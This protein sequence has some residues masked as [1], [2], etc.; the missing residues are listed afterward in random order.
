MADEHNNF[1][2]IRIPGVYSGRIEYRHLSLIELHDKR[3]KRDM[4]YF[5]AYEL[6]G[7]GTSCLRLS[8]LPP[9]GRLKVLCDRVMELPGHVSDE[10]D[11]PDNMLALLQ[12]HLA[13][14]LAL[15]LNPNAVPR[16]KERLAGCSAWFMRHQ[17]TIDRDTCMD[18]FES[19]KRFGGG[20]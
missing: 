4:R 3:A 13:L 14:A 2:P 8:R 12:A 1:V 9:D 19:Y 6:G 5:Y 18:A 16:L 11:L 17:S 7:K 20:W 15:R 10:I